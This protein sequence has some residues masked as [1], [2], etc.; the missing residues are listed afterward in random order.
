MKIKFFKLLTILI[1]SSYFSFLQAE[2]VKNIQIN[3]NKRISD[4][5]IKI[6]GE[7]NI[8]KNYLE[9]DINNILKNLYSTN[10]FEDV[11]IELI[12]GVLKVDLVEYPVINELLILGESSTK[13]VDRIKEII[14]LKAKNSFIKN[15][16]SKDIDTIKQVYSSLGYNF[17]SIKTKTRVIDKNNVDLVFEID[18]GEVTKIS[19]ITFSGDKKVRERRLRDIIASEENKFWKF[20]S[21]NT[22]YSKNLVELDKRLLQNYYKSN[23]YYDDEVTSNSAELAK[24]G[25]IHLIYSIEAG[26][27]YFIKKI[28]T[29]V[30][31]VFDKNIFYPLNKEYKKVVG[32][33]YSPFKIKDLLEEIDVLIALNNLQFVE[34][35]VEES[36]QGD[37]INV[38]INI[39]EGD[40]ILVERINILGNTITNESVVRGELLLDEGD[41]FTELSLDK[42]ISNIQSRNIFRTVTRS[43][44]NGSSKDLKIIDISVE[45]KPTGEISAGAGIGTNG[46]SLAFNVKENNWLGEGKGVGFQVQLDQSSLSGVINYTDPNYDFLGNSLNFFV[47][48]EVNDKKDS[49]YENN[50]LTAGANTSFEQYKDLYARLGLSASYDDLKTDPNASSTLKKQSGTF[51]E[52]AANYGFSLDKRNRSFKPTDGSI[53]SFNQILP[54]YADKSFIQNSISSSTY[55]AFSENIIG[56]A[57]FYISGINGLNDDDVR[58]NKRINLGSGRLRGFEQGKIGPKDG[59][60][61]IGGNFASSANFE[62]TLPKLLPESTNTDVGFFVDFGNVWGVDYSDAISDSN[63]VRSSAG[64][65]ASWLSPLGPMTFILSKNFTKASTDVTETFNFNLGTTF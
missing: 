17:V 61:H 30:D 7:I 38:K 51:S 21:R 63:K 2:I 56:A 41:P 10:F 53:V 16:L 6:Y 55:N 4:E 46:G 59:E 32:S 40:K 20:I 37:S 60:D 50:I 19:K 33:Y 58:L 64:A 8:N 65:A 54:L 52:I 22:K 26:T 13:Y 29:N 18:R 39:V 44:S 27:R 24:D 62:M 15:D 34:H 9:V 28:T 5:T 35:N 36:I 49:G 12:N 57:K 48:N 1:F 14:S 25:N 42:S 45:E 23:G 43:V 3:G 47:E 11:K 31:P